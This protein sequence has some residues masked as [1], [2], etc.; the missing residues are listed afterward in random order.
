MTKKL[1]IK[2]PE[3]TFSCHQGY[4]CLYYDTKTEEEGRAIFKQI[5]KSHKDVVFLARFHDKMTKWNYDEECYEIYCF[6]CVEFSCYHLGQ[7]I[8]FLKP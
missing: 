4:I 5:Q 2:T 8:K 3:F 6:C 1:K 7:M